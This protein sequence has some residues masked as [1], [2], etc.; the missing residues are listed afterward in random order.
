MIGDRDTDIE[1]G[2]R[3]GVKTIKITSE[4]RLKYHRIS[5]LPNSAIRSGVLRFADF[6]FSTWGSFL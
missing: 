1:C 5:G 6:A 2:K 3:A 4:F